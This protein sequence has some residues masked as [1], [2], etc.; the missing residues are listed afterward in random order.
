M[1]LSNKSKI[2][3]VLCL[4]FVILFFFALSNDN[5]SSGVARIYFFDVGQG[6]SI[7]IRTPSGQN[8]LI[9]GGPDKKVLKKLG[10]VLPFWD[11]QIDF[12]ILSHPHDDHLL[13]LIETIRRYQI[14]NIIRTAVQTDTPADNLLSALSSGR[15]S[16]VT[17]PGEILLKDNCRLDILYPAGP[18]LDKNDLNNTSI[19]LKL[20]CG[21][22]KLLLAGDSGQKIEKELI[23]AK[24]DLK[25]DFL[26]ISHHGSDTASSQ[27]FLET[28]GAKMATISVGV[29]N[30]FNH[31][32]ARIISRLKNLGFIVYRTD[33]DG[34]I[35]IL[36]NNSQYLVK[37]KAPR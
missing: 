20:I 22:F 5:N 14:S 31:P 27:E 18:E 36:V 11:R 35:E 17:K 33:I 9:D 2:S 26:K 29:N 19:V 13:G 25:A 12:L 23:A 4:V 34:D 3:L 7:L 37:T 30:K 6:D 15:E 28:V 32:A 24:V 21:S 1:N 16:I 10:L 8:I